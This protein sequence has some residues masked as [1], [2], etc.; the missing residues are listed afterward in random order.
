M[1]ASFPSQTRM[2]VGLEVRD[3]ERSLAF[4]RI[5]LEGEPQK[6]R[7]GYAKFE[8]EE[9][10]LNLAL[11]EGR[12]V[13]PATGGAQHFGIQVHTPD[14]VR[15][16]IERLE[17]AGLAVRPEWSTQCC[18]AVQDKVWV[19]DPDGNSWE[20]FTVL[21]ADAPRREGDGACCTKLEP[22]VRSGSEGR[23]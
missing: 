11:I 22:A 13:A 6:V 17:A 9:P 8:R 2:H 3:L 4:Y 10:R 7:P 16:A 15:A 19:D 18:Y 23:G 20:V 1:P 12:G 14:A 5:L 21:E